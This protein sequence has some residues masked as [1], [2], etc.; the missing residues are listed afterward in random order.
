MNRISGRHLRYL[1]LQSVERSTATLCSTG[2]VL[3]EALDVLSFCD[4]ANRVAQADPKPE[5]TAGDMRQGSAQPGPF[6]FGTRGSSGSG[7]QH[8]AQPGA[9][10]FG[11][12]PPGAQ[13]EA[14]TLGD[15][16]RE[17]LLLAVAHNEFSL[18]LAVVARAGAAL[19]H[20]SADLQGDKEVVLA[21]VAQN[22][23]ALEC[24]SAEFQGDGEVVLAA[25]AQDGSALKYASAELQGDREV[26]LA[27]VTNYGSALEYASAELQRD[28]EALLTEAEVIRSLG[29]LGPKAAR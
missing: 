26:V 3:G 16:R 22:A 20:A 1:A 24:V 10:S 21:A 27:A 14:S 8:S 18:V 23:C 15:G 9:F 29:P 6:S 25:V 2:L 12:A 11:V 13:T 19:E 4:V 7:G 5:H 28:Q 17:T